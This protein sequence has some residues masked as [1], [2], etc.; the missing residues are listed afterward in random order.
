MLDFIVLLHGDVINYADDS[1]KT[2]NNEETSVVLPGIKITKKNPKR[3][4]FLQI[5]DNRYIS[6]LYLYRMKII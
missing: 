6:M 3:Y 5:T 1:L 2:D 4:R